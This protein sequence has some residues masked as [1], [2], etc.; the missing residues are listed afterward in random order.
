MQLYQPELNSEA[1]EG[2]SMECEAV[3]SAIKVLIVGRP[4]VVEEAIQRALA[5]E[6][7]VR[8]MGIGRDMAETERLL[9]DARP[10]VI[11]VCG[12]ADGDTGLQLVEQIVA[13]NPDAR[14]VVLA[15]DADDES[16]HDLV[17]AGAFGLV[18]LQLDGFAE[19]VSALHRAAA[20]EFLL[21]ADTL[22]RI[23]RHQRM[24]S[25]RQRQRA[26][27]IQRLTE[28]ELE[29][30][31]LIGSGLDNRMI[32]EKLFV[33]VTTV[34]SHIQ[35]LLSKLDL[36]SRV[37]VAVLANQYDLAVGMVQALAAHALGSRQLE[38]V[39]QVLT[40]GWLRSPT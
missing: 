36:H 8:V 12:G 25:V 20:G 17:T 10:D 40:S 33:S 7:G 1:P 22:R 2:D 29:V 18:N 35:H 39:P 16:L 31:S 13:R 26:D 38:H 5:T 4:L 6:T 34:R 19:L 37:E 11:L 32:A 3:S 23:I 21:S 30:L 9:V 28:R 15:P 14:V 24:Q 27:V